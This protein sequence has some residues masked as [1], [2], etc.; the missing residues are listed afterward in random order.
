ML[1][2]KQLNNELLA[3]LKNNNTGLSVEFGKLGG[4]ADVLPQNPPCVWIYGQPNCE[5]TKNH[6][7]APIN[8]KAAFELFV[9]T[10]GST[11]KN[12]GSFLDCIELAETISWQIDSFP[13][14]ADALLSN[15]DIGFTG[16]DYPEDF[17]TID[18]IYGDLAVVCLQFNLTYSLHQEIR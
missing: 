7:K 17:L 18:G 6:N 3:Y 5:V 15:I 13:H 4:G 14:Y 1:T 12:F 8:Y 2:F 11:D 16:L 10:S 9:C